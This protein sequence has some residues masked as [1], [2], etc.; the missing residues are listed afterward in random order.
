MHRRL[1]VIETN[2]TK[3]LCYSEGNNG[4][5]LVISG[6]DNG[7]PL[8]VCFDK[9]AFKVLLT[10]ATADEQLTALGELMYQV[11]IF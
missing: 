4:L 1:K 2:C 6:T 10:A 3:C 5:D 9:Q 11:L 7:M 8:C